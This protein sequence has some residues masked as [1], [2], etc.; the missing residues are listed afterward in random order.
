[1][2]GIFTRDDAIEGRAVA[3]PYD[4]IRPIAASAQNINASNKAEVEQIKKR[5]SVSEWQQEAWE[6][7][8]AIGEVKYAFNLVGNVTSRCRLFP[9]TLKDLGSSPSGIREEDPDLPEGLYEAAVRAMRRLES[10]TGGQAALLRE[11]AINISVTGEC[12]LV[13]QPASPMGDKPESWDIKSVDEV[14]ASSSGKITLKSSPTAGANDMVE[15]P[16][17]AFVG[18]IWRPHPRYG[19][20]A[21][22]SMRGLLD[23]MSELLLLNRAFR[24]TARSRLNAGLLYIPDG[25]AAAGDVDSEPVYDPDT[26][27]TTG[28]PEE[29]QDEIEDALMES[30]TA[31]IT[32]ESS[33][34]AVVPIILRGPPEASE[35]IK[36]IKFERSFDQ[37]LAQRAD[38]VLER[39]LL[40]LDVPKDVVTGLA[41]VRYSNAVRIDENLYKAHIEPLVVLICDALTYIYLRPSLKA[42]GFKDEVIKKIVVWYDPSEIVTRPDRAED[43]TQGHDR[44]AVSDEAWR[45]SHGFSDEDAPSKEEVIRRLLIDKTQLLPELSEALMAWWAPQIMAEVRRANEATGGGSLPQEIQDVLL[46]D[47]GAAPAEP[48][49]ADAAPLPEPV[50]ETNGTTPLTPD[51]LDA[52]LN[53]QQGVTP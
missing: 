42:E 9:A 44:Y 23:L 33:A 14:Q 35:A 24:A 15:L 31:P 34:A 46:P 17:K 18:R 37:N 49:P 20:L 39:I 45:R 1:M 53:P 6:Y 48:A 26:G 40:G 12:F 32:D 43:A 50:P 3:R 21:D 27:T 25:I 41:Q 7:V 29:P 13:Q 47:D 11:A 22:S 52:L 19:A 10:S 30:M 36:L 4:Y 51:N 16:A 2:A 28:D 38:R 5:A 8:D